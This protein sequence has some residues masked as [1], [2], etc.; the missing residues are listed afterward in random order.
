[1]NN[2]PERSSNVTAVAFFIEERFDFQI[3]NLFWREHVPGKNHL[4]P[5]HFSFYYHPFTKTVFRSRFGGTLCNIHP[6]SSRQV[7]R[8]NLVRYPSWIRQIKNFKLQNQSE[9]VAVERVIFRF[10]ICSV[11]HHTNWPFFVNS[12][13]KEGQS[14]EVQ[15]DIQSLFRVIE[16]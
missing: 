5:P 1:M 7:G 13:S 3:H 6:S 8:S 10:C 16:D 15:F 2:E 14:N 11:K 12:K 4:D 9:K